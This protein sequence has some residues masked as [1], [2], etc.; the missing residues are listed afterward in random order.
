M[1]L[2][3]SALLSICLQLVA[4]SAIESGKEMTA[5]GLTAP[6]NCS[7]VKLGSFDVPVPAPGATD[8]LVRVRG[9]SVNHLDLLW[10]ILKPAA[11]WDAAQTL[12]RFPKVL[13]MDVSGTVVAVGAKVDRLRVGDD[14]WAFNAAAAVYDGKTLGGLAGHTWAP[15]VTLRQEDAGIK[16]QNINFTEAG[17]LP[18]VAQTSLQALKLA[19]APFKNGSTVLI[20]GA[21]GGTGHI[22]VQLAKAFGATT[23][24]VTASSSKRAFA[25]SLG[26]DRVIDYHTQNWWNESVIPDRSLDAIYD[27]VLQPLTGDRAYDKL[28]DD[29]KFVSLCTGIPICGAPMPSLLTKL[30]RP[31]L[32]SHALRCEAGTCASVENLNELRSLV[33]A[34]KL[35]GYLTAEIPYLSIQRA[36]DLLASHHVVGKVALTM[37]SESALVV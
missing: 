25:L 9:S 21:T 27:T 4:C 34:G 37:D 16:P 33:E 26:A 20:L 1:V 10:T 15:Y 5:V 32:A 12:W 19:G 2:S 8:V 30:K 22:A 14:V 36:V 7:N 18:L 13:G 31:S 23:V 24:I 11:V 35:H 28:K 29:G 3:L 17:S 6:Q